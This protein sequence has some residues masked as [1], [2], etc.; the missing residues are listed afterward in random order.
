M[1]TKRSQ[2]INPNA[3][4]EAIV[5]AARAPEEEAPI[6]ETPT[7]PGS[8]EAAAPAKALNTGAGE[9]ASSASIPEPAPEAQPAPA[10]DATPEPPAKKLVQKGYYLTEEQVK[11][12]G[13]LAVM[14]GVD[15][16]SIVRDALDA[17]FAR[18]AGAGLPL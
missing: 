10:V 4:F 5:G 18:H 1:A 8:K 15:R 2:R 7:A 14:N 16:S 17:W 11:Q 6:A 13:I 3:A 9:G 12:L